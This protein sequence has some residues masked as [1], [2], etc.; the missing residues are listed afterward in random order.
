MN[1]NYPLKIY[2]KLVN[3]PD[4]DSSPLIAWYAMSPANGFEGA[5]LWPLENVGKDT[6][7]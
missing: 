6:P 2:L 1:N 7:T 4:I 3:V 5:L